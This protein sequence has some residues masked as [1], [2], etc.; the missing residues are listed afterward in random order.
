MYGNNYC[1]IAQAAKIALYIMSICILG[2]QCPHHN[3]PA[4]FIVDKIIDHEQEADVA[5]SKVIELHHVI[6]IHDSCIM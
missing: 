2:L 5:Q 1:E 3:N 4:D 6:V